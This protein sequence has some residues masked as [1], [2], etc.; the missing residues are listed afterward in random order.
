[1]NPYQYKISFRLRH[2]SASLR[3][4]YDALCEIP[5]VVPGRLMDINQERTRPDGSKLEGTYGDSY[6][7]VSFTEKWQASDVQ[8][9]ST[10]LAEALE[11]IR[12]V[13][14]AIRNTGS[15]VE[16]FIGL[17]IAAN[18]GITFGS[19]LLEEIAQEKIELSFDIY[20]GDQG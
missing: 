1:M 14:P 18:S 20:P 10:A 8:D 2:G 6:C 4:L 13:L 12:G 15:T 11:K 19:A 7:T 3:Q 9:L 16:F 5:T 17:S